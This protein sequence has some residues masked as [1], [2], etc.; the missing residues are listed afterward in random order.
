MN[1]DFSAVPPTPN[2]LHKYTTDVVTG[3]DDH[4]LTDPPENL[5]LGQ[6]RFGARGAAGAAP[7]LQC[8]GT[9]DIGFHFF[10][11]RFIFLEHLRQ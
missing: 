7:V 10:L 2:Q 5:P 4:P 3:V 1:L 9:V 6:S 8:G 11:L